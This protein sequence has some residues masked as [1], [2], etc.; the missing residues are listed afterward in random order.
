MGVMPGVAYR[1][2]TNH[3][4]AA[5]RPVGIVVHH[6]VSSLAGAEARFNDPGSQASAHFFVEYDGT[7]TQFVDVDVV[8][9]HAC[10]ANYTGWVGVEHESPTTG[11]LFP[12]L[13][14]MQVAGTGRILRWLHETYQVPLI[15]SDHPDASGVAYH[16]MNPGD[17]A[18][19]WGVTGCPGAAIIAQRQAIVDAAGGDD[20]TPEQA[21]QLSAVQTQVGDLINMM[22]DPSSGVWA[23]G[24]PEIRTNVKA[25]QVAVGKI[26]TAPLSSANATFTLKL[27]GTA[28]PKT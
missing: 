21:A 12:P 4:G 9:W 5:A 3:G 16:S 11:D 6:A 2:V 22:K 1:P 20:M 19:H 15:V 7:V 13:T 26:P 27:D 8:A 17:C 28:T 24:I 14:G 10:Q 18:T 23:A 25:L